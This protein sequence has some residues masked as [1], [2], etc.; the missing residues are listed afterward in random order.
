MRGS[1]RKIEEVRGSATIKPLRRESK[2]GAMVNNEH[3]VHSAFGLN[4][5]HKGIGGTSKQRRDGLS[6]LATHTGNCCCLEQSNH[7]DVKVTWRQR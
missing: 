1:E 5:K 6:I 7:Q 3:D 4:T 2:M